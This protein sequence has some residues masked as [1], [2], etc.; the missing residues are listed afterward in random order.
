MNHIPIAGM[1]IEKDSWRI[2]SSRRAKIIDVS[3]FAESG[4]FSERDIKRYLWNS[5]SNEITAYLN[6]FSV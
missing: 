5:Y 6:Y 1:N 4:L 3:A 2:L